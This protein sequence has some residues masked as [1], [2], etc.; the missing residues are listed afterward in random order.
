MTTTGDGATTPLK[1]LTIC[2]SLR[3][4]SY[5]RKLMRAAIEMAPPGF[6]ITESISIGEIPY[7]NEDVAKVGLPAPVQRINE[8]VRGA[9]AVVFVTPEYNYGVPG[10]LKNVID[11]ITTPHPPH[12][13]LRFKP[14]ALMG[15]SIGNFGTVRCQL[16]LRQTFLFLESYVMPKPEIYLFRAQ[17][18]FGASGKLTDEPARELIKAYWPAL[19]KFVA[20]IA[21]TPN[22]VDGH[23]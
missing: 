18:K 10:V 3:R 12:N 11:W 2:G 14:V 8:Q 5:N 22:S 19:R 17:D 6:D 1:V 7:L 21:S 9:D 13:A 23:A 20:M 4:E 16:S 15:A